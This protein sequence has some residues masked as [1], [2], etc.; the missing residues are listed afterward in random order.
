MAAFFCWWRCDFVRNQN[1]NDFPFSNA[2]PSKRIILLPL[3][4]PMPYHHIVCLLIHTETFTYSQ[5]DGRVCMSVR[6]HVFSYRPPS[7]RCYMVYAE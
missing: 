2:L 6:M 5:I 3:S 1:Q 7:F 4:K